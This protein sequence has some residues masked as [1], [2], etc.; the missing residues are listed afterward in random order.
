MR[1]IHLDSFIEIMESDD[2]DLIDSFLKVSDEGYDF[3]V[4]K[5]MSRL[6]CQT[7]YKFSKKLIEHLTISQKEGYIL[8]FKV[9]TGIREEFDVLRYS[10]DSV[11]N[12]ELKSD[13]PAKGM[14]AVENQLIRHKYLLNNLEKEVNV[15]TYIESQDVLY[16]LDEYETLIKVDFCHIINYITDD[17][18]VDNT[19]KNLNL[20]NMI[21]SPYTQSEDFFKR[22]YFLTDEQIEKRRNILNS[23]KQKICLS[24]GP[25]T[26]KTLLLVDIAKK[27]KEEGKS[28]VIVF[29]SKMFESDA[30]M[31]SD[32]LGID[33]FPVKEITNNYNIL[34]DYK[35][36]LVDEAHRIWKEV[37]ENLLNKETE[38]TIFAVDHKQVMHPTEDELNIEN[39]LKSMPDVEY[40]RLKYRIRTDPAMSSFI[41]KFLNLGARHI[42]PYDYDNVQ[43]VYFEDKDKAQEYIKYKSE[44]E[45]Y[46]SIELTEYITK[47]VRRK[48]RS[49]IYYNSLGTH[50]VIGREYD[51]VI[52][53]LDKFFYYDEKDSKLTTNYTDYYPYLQVNQ[54]FQALTRV[55]DKLIILILDNPELYKTVQKIMT[56]KTTRLYKKD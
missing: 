53:S 43:I 17:Y 35:I 15:F 30:K 16:S 31:I 9:D 21:I 12:I 23:K 33:I 48:V 8:G 26:G 29:G 6:E 13:L 40:F 10:N 4:D 5:G 2:S 37:F 52:V 18:I 55:K 32:N 51:N 41:Q 1:Y 14:E 3:K 24:G 54:I 20:N 11:L 44:Q 42:Q 46:I 22:R 49:H 19:L 47:I 36:I 50:D 56:W 34:D 39:T 45:D 28:V 38:K 27:Y 25:G 7:F